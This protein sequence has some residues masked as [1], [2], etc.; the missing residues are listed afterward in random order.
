[1]P[2]KPEVLPFVMLV[3][4]PEVIYP[5]CIER[6]ADKSICDPSRYQVRLY[7]LEVLSYDVPT[8]V[9]L[10]V[11]AKKQPIVSYSLT[12]KRAYQ[13]HSAGRHAA[14]LH[15]H[16]DKSS[17]AQQLAPQWYQTYGLVSVHL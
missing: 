2:E 8:Y 4:G 7:K 3:H 10:R 11:G 12:E 14:S 13:S 6:T 15:P 1:V 5:C 17:S 16:S 9:V